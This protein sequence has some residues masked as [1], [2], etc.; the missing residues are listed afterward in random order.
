MTTQSINVRCE[1]V[2]VMTSQEVKEFRNQM[3]MTQA[4]F[5]RFIGAPL[6]TIASWE[7]GKS[8]STLAHLRVNTLKN[9]LGKKLIDIKNQ[10]EELIE[11]ASHI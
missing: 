3:G 11:Q 4:E 5:A 8:M 9:T 7:Y 1:S 2:P 6:G 10:R